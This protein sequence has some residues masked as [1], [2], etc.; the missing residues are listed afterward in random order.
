MLKQ[1]AKLTMMFQ[2]LADPA[3]RSMVERLTLGPASVSELARPFSMSLSAVAQHLAVLE[4]SGLVTT[5]KVGRV[6]ICRLDAE[7]LMTAEQWLIRRLNWEG[8]F[9]RLARALAS[10]EK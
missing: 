4:Q 10:E 8:R 7:A 2:A 6:R 5:R 1:S 9:T 3:R